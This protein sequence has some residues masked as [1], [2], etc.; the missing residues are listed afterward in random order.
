MC[1]YV[2]VYPGGGGA[3]RGEIEGGR[4]LNRPAQQNVGTYLYKHI[5]AAQEANCNNDNNNWMPIEC[6]CRLPNACRRRRQGNRREEWRTGCQAPAWKGR[7]RE[8][9]GS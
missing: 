3:G 8:Q 2:L 6:R 9:T 5:C 7:A 1:L 4:E